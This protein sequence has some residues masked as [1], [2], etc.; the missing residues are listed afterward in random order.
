MKA[1]VLFY[2]YLL[3][4]SVTAMVGGFRYRNLPRPLRI[5]E[6]MIIISTVGVIAELIFAS[7]HIHNLWMS[8]FYTLIELV[9][10][11]L[12]CSSWMKQRRNRL[13]VLLCLS[14]FIFLWIISKFTF[15]PFSLLDG[16]TSAISKILQITFSG[17]ILVDVV[18]ESDIVWTDDPRLW[19]AGGV[20]IYAAGTLFWFAL[21]NK[22]LQNSPERLMQVYSLN[23]ILM[24]ISNLLYAR[25]FLCKK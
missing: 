15:E 23:W 25:G 14:M 5:L 13:L 6:W 18:K 12:I 22:M 10:V 24:I 19:I 1:P 21:F 20:I 8:H 2:I 9:C 11:T 17:F 4:Q 7:L 16:W 3:V